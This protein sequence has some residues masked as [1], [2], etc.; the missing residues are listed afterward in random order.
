M[1]ASPDVSSRHASSSGARD[2]D[3]PGRTAR[4]VKTASLLALLVALTAFARA[5]DL[6]APLKNW[7]LPLFNEH[8]F[9]SLT[10]RGS[11]AHSTGPHEFEVAGLDL[12]FY[13]GTADTRVDT[14][15]LSPAAFFDIDAKTA[16]GER[17][18]RFIRDDVEAAGTRWHYWRDQKKIS[19]DGNVH[20]TFRA[21]LPDLLK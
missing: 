2:R 21:E 18:V 14:V 12:T 16:R 19:L 6:S 7:V 4:G 15:I 9:R 17:S 10:A 5:A 13:N 11:E 8:N 3:R 20:V 1:P